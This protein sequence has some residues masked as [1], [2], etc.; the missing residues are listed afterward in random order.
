M[1]KNKT[2]IFV[3]TKADLAQT[4]PNDAIEISSKTGLNIDKLKGLIID[5]I[6]TLIPNDTT[7]TTNK[8]QQTC[9]IKAKESLNNALLTSQNEMDCSD[10]LAYDLK[11]SILALDEITGAVLTDTILDDIFSNFCIGK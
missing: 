9:L 8:R 4:N 11:D 3:K 6:K 5:K 2:K 7:Y 10:L 1:A